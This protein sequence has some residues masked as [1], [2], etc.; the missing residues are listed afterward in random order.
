MPASPRAPRWIRTPEEMGR[1]AADLGAARAVAIDTE[2]DSLHHYPG[3]LCLVQAATDAGGAHLV[4]PLALPD[5]S[6]FGPSLADPGIVKIFHAADN[7]L[8]YLKR[9]H[10][11]AVATIF[12]TSIAARF[13]GVTALGLDV[14][15]KSYLGVDS[16]KSRQ[17][18]DWS[19][20]PLTAEQETYA[21]NDVIHLIPLR[22]RLA[23]ELAAKGRLAWLEEECAALAAQSVFPR[24]SDPD[25]YLGLKGTKDLD[26]RGLAV[27]RE[28]YRERERLALELDRPPF[29]ILGHDTLVLLAARRPTDVA[30]LLEVPGCTPKFERRFGA[31]IL[32]AIARGL[33]VPEDGLPV[34]TPKPRPNVPGPMR[35]RIEALRA[36]RTKGAA[37]LGLDPGFFLPQRLIDRLAAAPPADLEALARTDGVHRWRAEVAGTEILQALRTA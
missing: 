19:R 34:R 16:G 32:A 2:A 36:W 10:A 4:D 7:D 23:E 1:L 22:E 8:A 9:Q 5:L 26:R 3:K 25:A 20:R 13:L 27:L 17:K 6:A 30:G 28:L 21:L 24:T 29:M 31:A 35:R 14:L 15:L 18:D 12:D 11:F 37:A 33:A